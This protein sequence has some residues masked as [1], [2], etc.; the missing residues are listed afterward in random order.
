MLFRVALSSMSAM[1]C[2][3]DDHVA[4]LLELHIR[5]LISRNRET[6]E[7][8]LPPVHIVQTGENIQEK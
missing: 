1:R 2:L 7:Q 8:M 6:R 5:K 4:C 3:R